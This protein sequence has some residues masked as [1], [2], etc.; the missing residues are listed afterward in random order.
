[1]NPFFK[2]VSTNMSVATF[3]ENHKMNKYNYKPSYQREYIWNDEKKSFLIDSILKNFP[4]P[5]IFLRQ[6]IDE[7]S[8]V[9]SYD[10]IDGKQRLLTIAGFIEGKVRIPF[11][12][13]ADDMGDQFVNGLTFDQLDCSSKSPNYKLF[14]EYKRRLWRYTL[15]IEFIDTSDD[16][17]FSDEIIRNVFDRL[18]RN[19]EPL[20]PQELRN[21]KYQNCRFLRLIKS[22]AKTP[23]WSSRLKGLDVERLEHH[24]FVSELILVIVL[25]GI[26][27]ASK[28][29]V[30]DDQYDIWCK[31]F[32]NDID[33]KLVKETESKFLSITSYM[34]NLNLDYEALKIAGVSHL[35]GIWC[36]SKYCSENSVSIGVASE[37]IKNM[38]EQYSSGDKSKES[39]QLYKKSM[40]YSTRSKRQRELRLRAINDFCGFKNS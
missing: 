30:L 23:F 40:S 39:L 35:Y 27:D 34:E 24:E 36:F 25:D 5:P 38:F 3:Y 29:D 32:E 21:A 6:K 22:L 37:R 26:L 4:I 11:D 28:R 8:G 18:N 17:E 10:V 16:P 13:G 15:P 14:Q 2:R 33:G 20:T 9:T 12:F 31:K 1:M 19:G 7:D